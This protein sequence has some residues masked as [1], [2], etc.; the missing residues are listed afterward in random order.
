MEEQEATR[1]TSTLRVVLITVALTAAVSFLLCQWLMTKTTKR[2]YPYESKL[3]E[4]QTIIDEY[5]IGD[6]DSQALEDALAKG[7]IDGL[8]D[9]WSYYIPKESYQSYQDGIENAYVGI[10]I[11]I[12]T[13]N[14]E[15]GVLITDVTPGGPAEAAGLLVGDV[16][17]AVEGV[18]VLDGSA[19]ALDL[20]G[21]KNLVRG[22]AG[23]QVTLTVLR[24]GT[25]RPCTVTRATIKTVNVTSE[26]L[27]D[28]LVY[29]RIR[30]FDKRTAED[31]IA[32]LE[33]ALSDG[34][35]GIIFDVRFN[36]GG[37]KS[38][39]VTLLDYILPEGPLFH[40]ESSDGKKTVDN[41][42]EAH[43][44]I[45]M[46]VLVNYDSYS[47]A[48]FFAAALQEYDYAEIVGERTYGKG[49]FQSAFQLSDG[50]AIN[51]SI[52]KYTTPHGV[53]LVGK[54][55]TPDKEVAL[56]DSKQADL[57]YGRLAFADD[58]QLQAAISLLDPSAS[59]P[60]GPKEDEKEPDKATGDTSESTAGRAHPY[61]AKLESLQD[62]IDRYYVG[63]PDEEAI[64]EALAAA[65][66][67]N[68]GD[69][70]SY[71]IPADLY[72]EYTE[73]MENEYV[74][75]GVT[76][77]GEDVERG[78]RITDVTPE[79]PAYRAGLEIGDLIVAV[80]GVPVLDGSENEIDL[81]ET[82]KRVRGEA[83]TDITLTVLHE[84]AEREVTIT[85]APIR[86]VNVTTQ[87]LE[88]EIC[89][90]K[91]RNFE[92]NACADTV[93]AI[94]AAQAAGAKGIVFD[95]RYNPGGLKSE[96]VDL[97]DYILPEGPLFRQVTYDGE[98]YVDT[99]D[100]DHIQIP[101]AVLVNYNS[102]SA[103]EFFAAALQEYDYAEIV[104]EQT[105]G[106]GRFQT[107]I[108]LPDGSAVNL[109]I[110]TYTTPKGVSLVGKGITPDY[111]VEMD[112]QTEKD[113]YY[114][115]L[116]FEDDEQLKTAISVLTSGEGQ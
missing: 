44:E 109:S 56:S 23:T 86:V 71:Y 97:L 114:G 79:S 47:A 72:R 2:Q 13:E 5:F 63:E 19:D 24:D 68:I 90:I 103:A 91:I 18:P 98:E 8:G 101:M 11:T 112:E 108:R 116:A 3:R 20:D 17:T 76:I 81:T 93:A 15:R 12:T 22:E 14:V 111:P 107:A 95:V 84:G 61:V 48:E 50:S 115:N 39:L 38:E 41:S 87:M 89:Y 78:A 30:N 10:G 73:T 85:R 58:E 9:E 31:T 110:G 49:Y 37:L 52:G 64:S 100:E 42:D 53:S 40:S 65:L 51:L 69:E 55:V 77:T 83:G 57:Y 59:A 80:E 28:G 94:E 106:K 66:V 25:E 46:A 16:I 54:G 7:M 74:G 43:I 1:G 82:K 45:P 34:A 99:S 6:A 21:T 27:D 104:G 67:D 33:Q 75:I 62:I 102:Y 26:M 105:Y 113:L 60:V 92:Q 88:Q 96:L 29:L 4:I 32:V 35:K 70:W 36:P